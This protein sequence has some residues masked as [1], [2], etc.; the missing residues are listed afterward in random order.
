MLTNTPLKDEIIAILALDPRIPGAS[1][2]AVAA[3]NGVVTL[4]GT[5]ESSRQRRAAAENARK[6]EGVYE[7]KDQLKVSLSGSDRR[8]DDEI[9][10]A[11]LQTLI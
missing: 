11:G 2:I 9:R 7:V 10:G 5:V 3:E 8:D 6:I 4:R 1:E